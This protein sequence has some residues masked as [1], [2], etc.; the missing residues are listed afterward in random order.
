MAEFL[1]LSGKGLHH[2]SNQ[3]AW[4]GIGNSNAVIHSGEG[5]VYTIQWLDNYIAW[6]NDA[7]VRIYDT[8]AQQKFAFVKFESGR[9]ADLFRCNLCWQK[10]NED[11]LLFIGWADEVKI[12]RVFERK[13]IDVAGGLPKNSLEI[14]C[15]FKTD[16]IVSGIAP[17]NE[18]LI[19]LLAFMADAGEE[20]GNVNVISD[21]PVKRKVFT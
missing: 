15:Q 2:R 5:P 16:F 12:G 1:N 9:R 13:A 18:D 8:T 11:V 21:A 19:I 7:G 10:R 20:A 6:A 4:F 14:I 3:E 17:F